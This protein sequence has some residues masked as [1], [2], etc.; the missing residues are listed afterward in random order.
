MRLIDMFGMLHLS[1]LSEGLKVSAVSSDQQLGGAG[2]TL[3]CYDDEQACVTLSE[4][5]HHVNKACCVQR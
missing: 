3:A 2:H 5:H 4:V 1:G